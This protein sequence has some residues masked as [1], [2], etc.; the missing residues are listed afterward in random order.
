[1]WDFL[2]QPFFEPQHRETA[3]RAAR[4]AGGADLGDEHEA[5][6]ALNRYCRHL[7]K[8]LGDS[9]LLRLVA[10]GHS[11]RLDA[12]SLCVVR[13]TLSYHS[14]IADFVFALQGLGSAPIS[15]FGT[16]DQISRYLPRILEGSAI[17][18]FALS[19]MRSGSDVAA[20]ETEAHRDGESFVLGGA[21]AWISNA[22]NADHYVVFV[23]T[24][25]EP[26]ARGL[27]AFIV[28]ADTPGLSVD[29]AFDLVAP[30]PIGHLHFN[31]CRVPAGNLLGNLDDGFKIA[32][33]TLDVFR[34][35][36]G[37]AANG[38]ARRA[39]DEA[40]AR[41]QGRHLFGQHLSDFQATRL[42]I[43]D[44]ATAV[45]AA[46]LL[47]H[48]AAWT[49]DIDKARPTKEAAMAK[50]YA[51]ESAQKVIDDAVQLFGAAGIVR[52]A[53]V[54]RLYREI[55]ALRIYEGTTEIQKLII[56]NQLLKRA[57]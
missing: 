19:E 40:V 29:T 44:M 52:G 8:S 3:E 36:V 48:R 34:A 49:Y 39:I 37:A 17:A 38:M 20:I 41:V 43:A 57:S 25:E 56:A 32:M 15:M 18:A 21:K 10:P 33:A 4:W 45:E 9:G 31:N 28:D 51:T 1:M 7:A 14:C 26:G 30:H 42:R 54:E 50:M 46:E 27:S 24:G 6:A 2:K 22:G 47:V 35:T 11:G 13:H 53:V 55:R 12:R 23:R 5:G 16:T